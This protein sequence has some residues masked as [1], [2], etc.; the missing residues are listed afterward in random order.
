MTYSKQYTVLP[1]ATFKE[2]LEEII[3]YLKYKLKEPIIAKKFYKI[4][5]KKIN[6]LEFMPERYNKIEQVYGKTRNLR[7]TSLG[8]YI[9][10]YE[11][12]N[13]RTGFYFTYFSWNSKLFESIIKF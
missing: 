6:S 4:V 9:I 7:K 3:Y 13:T 8:N 2:E 5:I 10:I 12:N 11:V 1:T